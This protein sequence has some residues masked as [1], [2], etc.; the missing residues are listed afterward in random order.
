MSWPSNKLDFPFTRC[1]Y[2]IKEIYSH[3]YHLDIPKGWHMT[4]IFYANRLQKDPKNLLPGQDYPRPKSKMYNKEEE[5]EIYYILSSYL[6][7]S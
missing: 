7:Y 2:K 1:L 5:W 4:N 3:S 6:V